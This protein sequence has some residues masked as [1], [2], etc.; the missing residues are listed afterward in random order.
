MMIFF[1]NIPFIFF[2]GKASLLAIVSQCCFSGKK[3]D[4]N[5]NEALTDDDNAF[6]AVN[7][8]ETNMNN[9]RT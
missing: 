2:A 1:C 7:E 3:E 9:S 4:K 5:P 8:G 6:F